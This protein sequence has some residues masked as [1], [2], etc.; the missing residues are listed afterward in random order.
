M[1]LQDFRDY[2]FCFSSGEFDI[3][4]TITELVENCVLSDENLVHEEKC[5]LVDA[6]ILDLQDLRKKLDNTYEK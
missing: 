6:M 4:S 2:Y 1:D 5:A 3:E